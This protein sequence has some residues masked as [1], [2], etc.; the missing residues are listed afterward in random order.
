MPKNDDSTGRIGPH[1]T[2]AVAPGTQAR[3]S[4]VRRRVSEAEAL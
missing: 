1:S 3:K 4:Y 2:G